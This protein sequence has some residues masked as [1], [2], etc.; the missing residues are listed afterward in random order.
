[1]KIYK[2]HK[3]SYDLSVKVIKSHQWILCE[4]KKGADSVG[5]GA[6]WR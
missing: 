1:M 5:I 4:K 3:K 6:L 2:S